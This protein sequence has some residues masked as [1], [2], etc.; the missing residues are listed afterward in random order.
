MPNCFPN[1]C[2]IFFS[3]KHHMRVLIPP[4]FHRHLVL[5]FYF[6]IKKYFLILA[7]L[8]DAQYYFIVHLISISWVFTIWNT[9]CSICSNLLLIFWVV[10]F[11]V[12]NELA[13]SLHIPDTNLLSEN[14]VVSTWLFLPFHFLNCVFWKKK[15]LKKYRQLTF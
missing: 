8:I 5:I 10:V 13:R 1:A 4:Y 2:A 6:L 3:C 12:C 11:I 9:S 14:V 15:R 7:A